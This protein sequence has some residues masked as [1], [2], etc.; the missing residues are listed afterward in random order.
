MGQST[1]YVHYVVTYPIAQHYIYEK[2]I[3]MSVYYAILNA[4]L[5]VVCLMSCDPKG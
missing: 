2:K 5:P 4:N 1:G 3:T